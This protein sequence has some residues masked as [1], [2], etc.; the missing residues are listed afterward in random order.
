MCYRYAVVS[1]GRV[2]CKDCGYIN[3]KTCSVTKLDACSLQVTPK[4]GDA[5]SALTFSVSTPTDT[6][7]WM[8]VLDNGTGPKCPL[9]MG[10]IPRKPLSPLSSSPKNSFMPAL[11]EELKEEDEESEE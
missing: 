5:G 1:S 4:D 6:D 3:L 9:Y 2:L 8:S 7:A 11:T 10:S